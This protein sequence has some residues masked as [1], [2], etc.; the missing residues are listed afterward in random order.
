MHDPDSNPM[1][2]PA[3]QPAGVDGSPK[4]GRLL[5]VLAGAVLLLVGITVLSERFYS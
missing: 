1:K 2:H 4:F 5:I 3:E